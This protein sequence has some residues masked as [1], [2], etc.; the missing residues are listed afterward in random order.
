MMS[1]TAA[2]LQLLLPAAAMV[3]LVTALQLSAAAAAAASPPAPIGL[4]GCNT[5]CG[6]VSVP[7][8]FGIS[9]GCYWPGLNLTCDTSHDPPR[10]L[11]GDG[12]LRVTDIFLQNSTVRVVRAG[13]S[14]INATGDLV[15]DSW[16]TFFGRGFTEHGYLLAPYNNELVAFGCNVFATLLSEGPAGSKGPRRN[17]GGCASLCS[18]AYNFSSNSMTS[19]D[20]GD[21]TGM[22]IYTGMGA[23]LITGGKCSGGTS[24]CCRSF[25]TFPSPPSEVQ[26][27]RFD[28]GSD[29]LLEEKQLPVKVFVA[30]KGWIDQLN[31]SADEV[32]EVPFHL[33]WGVSRGL[34]PVPQN[35]SAGCDEDVKRRLCKSENSFCVSDNNAGSGYRC[36]CFDGYGVNPYLSTGCQG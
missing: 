14:I 33:R 13:G 17:I 20:T 5:T 21:A 22:S 32:R 18:K 25:V 35:T 4:H 31:V 30:E 23:D 2:V 1:P 8:P 16:S 11:L 12:T 24:G 7:Y 15:S 34:P 9:P 29:T 3:L 27:K 6:N 19:M 36:D 10:L 28:S 26:A